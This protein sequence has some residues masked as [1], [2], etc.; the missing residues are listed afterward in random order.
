M[1]PE[2][3]V[4]MVLRLGDSLWGLL[5]APGEAVGAVAATR[6]PLSVTPGGVLTEEEEGGDST[7][8]A[9]TPVEVGVEGEDGLEVPAFNDVEA[10]VW[11]GGSGARY[12][13]LAG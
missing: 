7:P 2:T 3:R 4:E 6:G 1:V 12:L 5:E 11:S 13:T 10:P 8:F 9:M